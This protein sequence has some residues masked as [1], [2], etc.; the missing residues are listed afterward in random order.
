MIIDNDADDAFLISRFLRRHGF[1]PRGKSPSSLADIRKTLE[2]QAW[3][4]VICDYSLA[5]FSARDVAA[6]ISEGGAC[7]P[8]VVV[9]G[10]DRDAGGHEFVA[11]DNLTALLPAIERAR[12]RW[13]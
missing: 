12:H 1:E 10:V 13:R 2:E 11:K 8:L 6:M 5:G 9:S 4:I 7:V 3:D